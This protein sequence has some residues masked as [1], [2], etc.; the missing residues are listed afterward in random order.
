MRSDES[1]YW[2]ELL[3]ESEYLTEL[4]CNAMAK[5]CIEVLK[6]LKSIILTMKQKKKIA[7]FLWRIF[8]IS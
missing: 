8:H 2:L 3:K 7:K 6:I 5:D 1:L 4:E